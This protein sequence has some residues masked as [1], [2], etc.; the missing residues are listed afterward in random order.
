MD[1]FES[2]S[3][4]SYSES[5]QK[6]RLDQVVRE[7][8]LLDNDDFRCNDDFHSSLA[9]SPNFANPNMAEI[10]SPQ[11]SASSGKTEPYRQSSFK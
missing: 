2:G 11:L 1:D 8:G 6:K 7:S 9:S 4:S 10:K 5:S 3:Q